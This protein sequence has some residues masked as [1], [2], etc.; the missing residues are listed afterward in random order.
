MPEGNKQTNPSNANVGKQ[1]ILSAS[2]EEFN[3]DFLESLFASYHDRE[4]GTFKSAPFD[5]TSKI[6]LTHS[7][8]EWVQDSVETSLGM[9]FMN[10]F[11]LEYVGVIKFI[12]YWN[13]QLDKKGLGA[14]DTTVNNFVITDQIDTKTLGRY[15][16]RRDQLGFQSAAF[17]S[18]SISAGL[19]RPMHDVNQR[20][21][22]LL[23]EHADAINSNNPT[24]QILAVNAIEKE[25]MGMVRKNLA[26]DV[27]YDMYASGD[28]NLD[29]NYKTINVMRGAVFNNITNR[30]DIV[31]ASLMDGIKKRDI[32]AFANSIVA[33]AYPSAVGTADSGY[34]AKII[35]A[36]LQSEHIDPDPNSDCG[37]TVTIPL[38][39]TDKNKQYALYRYIN[40][41]GNKV[42]TTLDNI[43]SYVG[44]TVQ[45]YS[46]QC[47]THDAIC[48]KC[49]GRVF[50]NLGV[51]Q[52]GLL[53]TAITQ[54]M[55]NLK[56]K[57]K[58]DLSQ[59]AA[60]IDKKYIFADE[61]KYYDVEDG[62]IKNKVP[63]KI[64]VP[65]VFDEFAGF[66]LEAT[67]ATC[68]GVVPVKFYDNSGKEILSTRMTVPASLTFSIYDDVQEDPEY[69]I[70]PYEAGSTVC[71]VAI[72]QNVTNVEYFI[73]QIYLYSKSPQLPYNIM[74]ELMFRCLEINNIDLT[75]PSIT[76]EMMAR[77]VC[78]HNGKPF[79][80]VFGKNGSVDPLKYDKLRYREAVQRAGILQGLLFEDIST[81]INVGLAQSLNGI[82]PTVTP[83]EKVI[84]A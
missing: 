4:S 2:L 8:Y 18:V 10:R 62:Y 74:T 37:T 33:G 29:N 51:T 59:K 30:Y 15:I 76:Y 24:S 52:V 56:L 48:G 11:L 77:R 64:F 9:L 39:I 55:L 36:L 28:G 69:Y 68:F 70:I 82:E 50:H 41:G 66:S 73:N 13:R 40:D 84:K 46:P 72:R 38:T 6:T 22:E 83:L 19:I 78:R 27:G 61:N 54:K 35:L 20:K 14:L 57:S 65:R 16:D 79:A 25:L 71:S 21:L 31:D 60:I 5:P 34:M 23:Q 1:R 43:G 17:L 63:M 81:A 45:M 26:S 3:K 58:H 12:G 47:C 53:V 75:G 42:L 49:A 7:E 80:F 67:S 44:K 32:P